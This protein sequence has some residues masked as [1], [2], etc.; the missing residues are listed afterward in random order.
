MFVVKICLFFVC[1]CIYLRNDNHYNIVIHVLVYVHSAGCFVTF[2]LFCS[3]EKQCIPP[4]N[5]CNY[6][7]PRSL[8]DCHISRATVY[9]L[10]RAGHFVEH[11][12]LPPPINAKSCN[13]LSP[14]S[15]FPLSLP[16]LPLFAPPSPF[17]SSVSHSI[18]YLFS[19]SFISFP[20]LPFSLLAPSP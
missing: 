9:R 17:P 15:L 1:P 12:Q 2:K 19:P 10:R 5:T 6:L 16:L 18:N 3:C 7:S 13:S 14:R 8:N 4:I 11:V 20:P